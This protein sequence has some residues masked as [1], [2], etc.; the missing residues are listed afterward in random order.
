MKRLG[1]EL[2]LMVSF[3][4]AV[5]GAQDVIP[6]YPRTPPGSKPESYPEKQ[7][8]SKSCNTDVVA[9]VTKPTWTVVKPSPEL[10]NGTGVVI[11]PGGGFMAL[12]IATE[13]TDVA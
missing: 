9:N 6:L 12:S 11:C 4:A 1:V 13:G 7:Y 5:A 3:L 8:F 10:K 2:L